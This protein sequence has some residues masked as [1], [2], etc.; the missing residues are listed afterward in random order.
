MSRRMAK[1]MVHQQKRKSRK[2]WMLLL[3]VMTASRQRVWRQLHNNNISSSSN[4]QTWQQRHRR[5]VNTGLRARREQQQ[6]AVHRVLVSI[7]ILAMKQM[8]R[9]T[10]V[11]LRIAQSQ[12]SRGS[13]VEMKEWSGLQ[14]LCA[15]PR[16]PPAHTCC[17]P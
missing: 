8:H 15:L 14:P 5:Q 12:R 6:W 16:C 2:Q 10:L 1:G 11:M 3:Q 7:E 4:H 17:L 9:L 13:R